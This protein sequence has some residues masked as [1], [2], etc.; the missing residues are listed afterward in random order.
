MP[1]LTKTSAVPSKGYAIT[2]DSVREWLEEN[3]EGSPINP[4]LTLARSCALDIL[5]AQREDNDQEPL[6]RCPKDTAEAALSYLQ[7]FQ[8]EWNSDDNE[9]NSDLGDEPEDDEEEGKSII[10]RKYKERYHPH[11]MTCGDD[12]SQLIT[13]HVMTAEGDDGK[14]CVDE[15]KLEHFAKLNGVWQEKYE[16]LNVGMRRMN[17]AN[18]LRAKVRHDYEIVWN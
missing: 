10:K 1:V 12:I 15:A 14:P 2:E 11:K 7:D 4:D 18:R 17:I 16:F 13:A 5:N 3:M 6:V 9:D 8:E